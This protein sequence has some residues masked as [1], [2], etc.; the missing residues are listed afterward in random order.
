MEL[1]L[2]IAAVLVI[3]IVIH[4]ALVLAKERVAFNLR[5]NEEIQKRVL[6]PIER[7][8]VYDGSPSAK[9]VSVRAFSAL[10]SAVGLEFERTSDLYHQVLEEDNGLFIPLVAIYAYA[11]SEILFNPAIGPYLQDRG[12]IVN[13]KANMMVAMFPLYADYVGKRHS[14]KEAKV[15]LALSFNFLDHFIEQPPTGPVK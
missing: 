4:F 1:M 14:P 11:V 5:N 15:I 9:V 12:S 7:S 6:E 2:P 3:L 10:R 13:K 8:G